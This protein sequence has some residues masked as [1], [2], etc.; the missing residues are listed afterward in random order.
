MISTRLPN[1]SAV[2]TSITILPTLPKNKVVGTVTLPFSPSD[3]GDS[4]RTIRE[5]PDFA[6]YDLRDHV[7]A[8]SA[9][10]GILR[11]HGYLLRWSP[12]APG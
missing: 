9:L 3:P 8:V 5:R 11:D 2:N 6:G 10:L 7:A 1:V 4:Q 12:F